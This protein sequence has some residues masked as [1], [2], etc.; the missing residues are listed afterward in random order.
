MNDSSTPTLAGFKKSKK[1]ENGRMAKD[2]EFI[3][4]QI[5]MQQKEEVLRL[6]KVVC[7][8]YDP[9]NG[10]GSNNFVGNFRHLLI[11]G[12]VKLLSRGNH[13]ALVRISFSTSNLHCILWIRYKNLT[14][15]VADLRETKMLEFFSKLQSGQGQLIE[16]LTLCLHTL[17]FGIVFIG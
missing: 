7:P 12:I 16:T 17:N 2:V 3:H 15:L 14:L 5:K 6:T 13:N 8:F 9:K 1:S 10:E 4:V 11:G